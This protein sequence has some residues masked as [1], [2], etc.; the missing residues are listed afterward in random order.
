MV[1]D[2]L[3]RVKGSHGDPTVQ[4][5][6]EA[7]RQAAL[8][9]A[10]AEGM[11]GASVRSITREAGVTEAVLYRHFTNKED[12]WKDIYAKIVGEMIHDKTELVDADLPLAE[13]LRRWV[14][15]TYA[16]YDGNR[17][18]FTYVLL[19]PSS[20]AESLGEV[21]TTQ[22]RLLRAV[23]VSGIRR[24]SCR[25]LNV[26]VALT[27]VAGLML[28][29]PRRINEGTL[30]GP[31]LRYAEEVAHAMARV[32]GCTDEPEVKPGDG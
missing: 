31:A 14:D 13:K 4:S 2:R 1:N 30:A 11:Q 32:L 25:E 29:V 7:L 6:K 21:Y 5:T 24:G 15:L 28:G 16:Y 27:M 12:L 8:K 19:M 10:G 17:D 9:V 26:D 3:Q 20:Y 23:L 18:A 22:S